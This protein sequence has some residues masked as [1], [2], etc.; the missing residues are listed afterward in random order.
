[1]CLGFASTRRKAPLAPRRCSGGGLP[2]TSSPPFAAAR[3]RG[4]AS[5][6]RRGGERSDANEHTRRPWRC[7]MNRRRL[8]D[9]DYDVIIVGGGPAGSA[10]AIQLAQRDPTLA[11]R[12]LL[13]DAAIFPREKLC[14]GGVVREADRL[15]GFI[16]VRIDVPTVRI[17]TIRFEYAGGQAFRRGHDLF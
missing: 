13:I 4:S 7:T 5:P 12:T 8:H 16:G 9:G 6:A 15:L 2:R 3:V 17:H 14:G 1:M 10:A 11:A